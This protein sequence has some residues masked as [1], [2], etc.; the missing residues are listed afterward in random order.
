M[1]D[2]MNRL[3]KVMLI[4]CVTILFSVNNL[5]AQEVWEELAEQL[6]DEDE[7]NSFQWENNFEELSE[8]KE[9]PININTATKKQLERFPFLSDQLVEN[10]LYYLYKYGPML[11]P[12]ELWMIEDIDRQTI[13]HLLPFICFKTPEKEEYKPTLKRILKY[14][15]QELSTRVDIPLYTKDGYKM[16][17]AEALKKNPNKQ[18][19]G[20][21]YYHNLR[22]SFRYRN[23]IYAGVTA[24]K[25]A[26]EPFF[27]GQNKKGYDFYSLYLLI[28]NIGKIN[29]L[30]IG[31]YRASYGYGLV[32]NTDFG[33]GKTAT[34]STLGNKNRGIRK[35]S[36]TDEYNYFRGVAG[37]Y[38][39]AE[40]W[41]LD[42]F[43]SYRRMDGIVDNRF[44][45][46]LKKDGYH[47][48][49]REF[50][51]KNTLSNQL[52]GSNLNYNG[53]YCELGLT[54][55]YNVFNKP[56]NPEKKYYNLYYP[57]G[58]D[59]YNVGMDYKFFW[60]RFSLLGETAIDKCGAL[61]T[62]NMLRYSPKGGTQLIVMNRY[63]DAKY[64]AIYARSV[65]E[66]STVQNESGF[67]IG[68][69]TNVL[70]YIRLTCY[71]DIF[72]FPWK[73]YRVS[74]AETKGFD[75][76]V[77]LSYSPTYEL[78]MFI[79][80]RY[81]NKKKDFTG[82]DKTKHTL[83]YIQQKCRY[84]LNYTLKDKL[85]LK[86][87][88]DY[89]HIN[90]QGQPASTGFLISQSATYK[91]NSLPFQ[92]DVSGAWFDTDDYNARLTIYEKNVLYAFSMPSFYY[93][94][95]RLAIN[96]RYELNKHIIIQ[97][98]YGTTH[99]LNREKISSALEE[100][101]GSTKSDLYLQLRLKF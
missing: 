56:L 74:E 17:S 16:H 14:S 32:I 4:I 6:V 26:G 34:L 89:A 41:T 35:H 51:K 77:Q 55:V 100:I 12:N 81:K 79:R 15:K 61:A 28:R 65:G 30:A 7:N 59:F 23:Q 47:R 38:R 19:L 78:E 82:E 53:K 86:T 18:Y 95:M 3:L 94:G 97:A 80:Y 24:E 44:I 60:K 8:L 40:R 46:S 33:M 87:I 88:V 50:E 75:G 64:Q 5:N 52:I 42:G 13:R 21:G 27:A 36:S 22:Y 9:N 67:Y 73:K 25:D 57:R 96:A 70:K 62:M 99:Y 66:G 85:L 2:K 84:Q 76:L 90:F 98:K 29:A 49:F 39:L 1:N 58:K 45:R 31:N 83:P 101:D 72:Y 68:L 91:F 93:K 37:S 71:G 11:T 10:I 43:Y 63:Y 92:L 48:L 20:Y 54:A 69:E